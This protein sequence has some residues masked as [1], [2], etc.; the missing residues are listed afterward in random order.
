MAALPFVEDFGS[1]APDVRELLFEHFPEARKLGGSIDG[2]RRLDLLWR[3]VLAG[4]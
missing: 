4:T 1:L 3:H 2:E